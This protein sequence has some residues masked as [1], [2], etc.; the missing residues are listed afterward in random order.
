MR[1]NRQIIPTADFGMPLFDK[2]VYMRIAKW[3]NLK[4]GLIFF[5]VL[6]HLSG[7]LN[8]DSSFLNSVELFIYTFH[9]PAFLFVS[10]LFS[11]RTI[12][13]RRYGKVIPYLMLYLFMKIFRFVIEFI[14]YGKNSRFHFFSENG[15]QWFALSLAL[16]Y[17]ITMALSRFRRSYL[18]ILAICMGM[19]AGYDSDLGSFLTGMRTFTLYPFFLA[20]YCIPVKELMTFTEKKTVKILSAVIL[21]TL[22]A[23]C[24]FFRPQLYGWMGFL[25]GK[26]TYAALDL[27]PY[28]G[29][30]RGIYYV[31]AFILVI[32]VIAVTPSADSVAARWGRR[33]L[34]VYALH[35]P[36][37]LVLEDEFHLKSHL[38]ALWPAHYGMLVPFI[39]LALTILLSA[40]VFEPFFKRLMN[41]EQRY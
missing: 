13:E 9:M 17:L 27:L 11:K 14:I 30:Y 18:M 25:R 7:V 19:M 2:E 4:F 22:F 41:P 37:L 33:T 29:L 32:A 12:D 20:G 35:Y 21:L 39:A 5:V 6:G 10:G 24:I 40:G 34:Q 38:Q 23:A 26:S 28:G 15:V 36:I 31:I 1:E 16:C 3:D 8:T